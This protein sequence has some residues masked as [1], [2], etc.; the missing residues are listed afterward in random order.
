MSMHDIIPLTEL[1]SALRTVGVS[2]SYATL[3]RHVLGGA[4]PAHRLGKC[5]AVLRADL[6]AI[7]ASLSATSR[8]IRA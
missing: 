2:K 4:I 1:P 8:R 5:W 3:H 7:A 6:P